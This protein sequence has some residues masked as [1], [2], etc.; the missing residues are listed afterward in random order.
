MSIWWTL[1]L[2]REAASVPLVRRILTGT[3]DTAGVD[4]EISYEIGLALTEA[5][6]NVV[7]HA[8]NGNAE[9]GYQVTV[10]IEDDC[11]RIE[12][13][14]SGPGFPETE[15]PLAAV[16]A[17]ALSP[18]AGQVRAIAASQRWQVQRGDPWRSSGPPLVADDTPVSHFPGCPMSPPGPQAESG[19]GMYLIQAVADHVQFRN[20]P[21]RGAVVCFDKALKWRSDSL[22][23]AS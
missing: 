17:G 3:M 10:L 12:V 6:A 8:G 15:E 11:C 7:E 21:S 2:R 5:C 9:E 18:A 14:D 23:R 13:V 19:R 22:L 20:H 16:T 1:R 4:P